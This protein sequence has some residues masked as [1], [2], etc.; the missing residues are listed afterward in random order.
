MK[1]YE[2]IIVWIDINCYVQWQ[3]QHINN[4]GFKFD[5]YR[6]PIIY[7]HFQGYQPTMYPVS[8]WTAARVY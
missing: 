6:Q 7:L 5:I 4:S 3:S 8:C 1:A 2:L